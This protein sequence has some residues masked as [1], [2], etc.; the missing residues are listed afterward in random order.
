MGGGQALETLLSPRGEG[1][2]DRAGVLAVG[3]AGDQPGRH[4]PVD[5]LDGA[6]VADQQV[7]GDLPHRRAPPVGMPPDGQQQLV[8]GGREARRLGLLAAPGQEPAQAGPE[9]EQ[10]LVVPLLQLGHGTTIVERSI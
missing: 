2:A 9:R 5:Q 4:R 6:V 7:A 1:D 3:L 10:A 8:L